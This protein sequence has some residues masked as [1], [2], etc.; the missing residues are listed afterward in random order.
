M[1]T[2]VCYFVVGL[3][4]GLDLVVSGY[5]HVFL[6]LFVVIV[7]LPY[8][9]CVFVFYYTNCASLWCTASMLHEVGRTSSRT[10]T[11]SRHGKETSFPSLLLMRVPIQGHGVRS[12]SS[13]FC[14]R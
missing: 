1:L 7:T 13:E 2:I 6:L 14:L 11:Y 8:R 5:A 10:T 4:L 12:T 9:A 3:G